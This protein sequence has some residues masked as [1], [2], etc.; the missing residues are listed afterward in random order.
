MKVSVD[1]GPLADVENLSKTMEDGKLTIDLEL[2]NPPFS[3]SFHGKHELTLWQAGFLEITYLAV[4]DSYS[5]HYLGDNQKTVHMRWVHYVVTPA[6]A[7]SAL[8]TPNYVAGA[9]YGYTTTALHSGGYNDSGKLLTEAIP[10][11]G[12]KVP[13]PCT[14]IITRPQVVKDLII[15]LNDGHKWTREKIADWLDTLDL[16]LT[17]RVPDEIPGNIN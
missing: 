4:L 16:D 7:W 13:S 8:P 6:W 10:A 15:H 9:F 17:F 1:N 12:Q 3:P 14:C 2:I 5:V 11:L